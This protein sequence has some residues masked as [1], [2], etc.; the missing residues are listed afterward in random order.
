[1]QLEEGPFFIIKDYRKIVGKAKSEKKKE[2]ILKGNEFTTHQCIPQN[3]KDEINQI[4]FQLTQPEKAGD[5][6]C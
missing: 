4:L 3:V 2:S 5:Q 6:N 1:M